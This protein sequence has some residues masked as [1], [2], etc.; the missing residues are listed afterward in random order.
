V[1][2]GSVFRWDFVKSTMKKSKSSD[3]YFLINPHIF[4]KEFEE[5]ER[6]ATSILLDFLQG[7]DYGAGVKIFRFDIYVESPVNYGR[8]T[9]SVY[10]G[11]AQSSIHITEEAF[12]K[13]N[14]KE[15]LLLNAA[16][17]SVKFLAEKVPLPKEFNAENL[18]KDYE[19]YLVTNSLFMPEAE[20]TDVFVKYF[21]TTRFNFLQTITA[22]VA[23]NKIHFDLNEIQDFINNR[24]AGK[25]FGTSIDTVDFGFELYDYNGG[26]ADF[27]KQTIG[28]KRYG[29]KLKNY[30]VVKHFDYSQLKELS[31]EEQFRIIKAKILEGIIDY[32]TLKRK[33]KDF[34]YRAFY[35]TMEKI[36]VEYEENSLLNTK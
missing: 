28:L 17:V 24:L 35:G 31:S 9:D 4:K 5:V 16:L 8:Q 3:G 34:D 32:D 22:E 18:A 25:N 23:S 36:L 7:K 19:R 14:E 2:S 26:F 27:L 33:P 12:H 30:L 1:K 10:G 20:C 13:S 11:Y 21:E 29:T 6:K 15:K